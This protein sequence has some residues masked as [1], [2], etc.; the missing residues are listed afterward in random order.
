MN[1]P[2]P[3]GMTIVDNRREYA[4]KES[5][6]RWE[7]PE[8]TMHLANLNRDERYKKGHKFQ[9]NLRINRALK[10]RQNNDITGS[11]LA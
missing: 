9:M 11:D 4:K 1:T 3:A 7:L 6:M 5:W 8:R 10:G 2:I